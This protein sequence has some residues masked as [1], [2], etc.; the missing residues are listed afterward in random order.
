MQRP[1]LLVAV[2]FAG[3]WGAICVRQPAWLIDAGMKMRRVWSWYIELD[4]NDLYWWTLVAGV[5]FLLCASGLLIWF[6]VLNAR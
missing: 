3:L 2:V 5:A 1:D 4:E 6:V